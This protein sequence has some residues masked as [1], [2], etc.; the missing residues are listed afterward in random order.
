MTVNCG[1]TE[2]DFLTS[3]ENGFGYDL[4]KHQ[5]RNIKLQ[6][7]FVNSADFSHCRN[8]V[9]HGKDAYILVLIPFP[10]WP[11]ISFFGRVLQ[12]CLAK[13]HDKLA[14][15]TELHQVAECQ[16]PLA[17]NL[18]RTILFEIQNSLATPCFQYSAHED[19]KLD[20]W[21]KLG[22][23]NVIICAEPKPRLRWTP[24][25]HER[26]VNAV[27]QLGGPDNWQW[28]AAE[29]T[30]K[31]VMRV[32]GVKGIT[33][34]H[35]KSHLQKFRLGKQPHKELNI[36][37]NKDGGSSHGHGLNLMGVDHNN[38]PNHQETMRIVDALHTQMEVQ[39]RLH[40]Q[41]EVQRHLQLKIESQGKYLQAILEKAQ[42]TLASQTSASEGLE[43]ARA[44]LADLASRV[45]TDRI[46]I[47]ACRQDRDEC[48]AQYMS[49]ARHC[50]YKNHIAGLVEK[51]HFEQIGDASQ[52]DN[53][54]EIS[55]T[56]SYEDV[57]TAKL[58]ELGL[59]GNNGWVSR[60]EEKLPFTAEARSVTKS[61]WELSQSRM[62][63]DKIKL[64]KESCLHVRMDNL[65]Q[66]IGKTERHLMGPC[67]ER[68]DVKMLLSEERMPMLVHSSKLALQDCQADGAGFE[69]SPTLKLGNCKN[70]AEGLDLNVKG[71]GSVPHK[72]RDL[73]LNV[74]G[75]GR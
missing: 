14:A 61:M 66:D 68:P 63:T 37:T 20:S 71:E 31:S 72:G 32:M 35:L 5:T 48:T 6:N 29:A 16:Y 17:L 24:E 1:N 42:R 69:S 50:S 23:S 13:M 74:H 41:L 56:Y 55:T 51:D 36:E 65:K 25:L 26:F 52:R 3:R 47:G 7:L 10:I 62:E 44:E 9:S 28:L 70:A 21:S 15:A 27:N 46:N 40:E 53:V 18:N 19:A 30:P 64:M 8:S 67:V 75:W 58:Q 34:Y 39:K 73:D 12:E 22:D 45:L 60:T 43:A 49:Q 38:T 4:H 11:L 57:R 33:L 59:N 2:E 54:R